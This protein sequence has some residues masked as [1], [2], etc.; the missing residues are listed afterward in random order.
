MT[1]KDIVLA[2]LKE[3]GFDGLYAEGMCG[4]KVDDLMPCCDS[5]ENCIA[6]Y[7]QPGDEECDWYIGTKK[8][9]VK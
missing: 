9:D 2:H 7:L 1:V 8:E 4:C 6:G 5:V 3:H